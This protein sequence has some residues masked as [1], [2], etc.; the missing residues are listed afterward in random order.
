VADRPDDLPDGQVQQGHTAD[1]EHQE[2]LLGGVGH[3]RR[4]VAAGNRQGQVLGHEGL[5]QPIAAHSSAV[6]DALRDIEKPIIAIPFSA[7]VGLP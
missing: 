7:G 5:S 6:Q 3:R 2:D 4:R 1:A